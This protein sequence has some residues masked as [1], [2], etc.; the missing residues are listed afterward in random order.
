MLLFLVQFEKKC[1][2]TYDSCSFHYI[3]YTAIKNEWNRA[4]LNEK[5]FGRDGTWGTVVQSTGSLSLWSS[6]QDICHWSHLLRGLKNPF[7]HHLVFLLSVHNVVPKHS[8]CQT[9][10]VKD[11]NRRKFTILFFYIP[12]LIIA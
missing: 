11:R 3:C 5:T 12:S 7:S 2:T 8:P 1:Y 4:E 6:Q 9:V 10:I